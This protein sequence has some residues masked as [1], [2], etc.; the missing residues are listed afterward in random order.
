[1]EKLSRQQKFEAIFKKASTPLNKSDCFGPPNYAPPPQL[2]VFSTNISEHKPKDKDSKLFFIEN[3]LENNIF[4]KKQIEKLEKA[5]EMKYCYLRTFTANKNKA[6]FPNKSGK[7]IEITFNIKYM[8]S[9]CV[10]LTK[11]YLSLNLMIIF[12]FEVSNLSLIKE[13][14]LPKANQNFKK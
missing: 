14:F 9:F 7:K 12:I 2:S 8:L 6:F 5:Q 3:H 11:S 13:Y 10:L 1:M 4:D